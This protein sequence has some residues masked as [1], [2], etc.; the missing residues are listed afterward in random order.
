MNL[1]GRS[2][3]VCRAPHQAGPLVE[4]LTED[5]ADVVHVP[6]IDVVGAADEGA[7]LRRAIRDA[8][9]DTWWCF[10]SSNAVDAVAAAIGGQLDS[11]DQHPSPTGRLAVVGG[12]T[13]DRVRSL[14]W[15]VDA[16]AAEPTARGLG[17]SLP[18]APG[19][20]V[21]APVAE[22]AS[23]D[24]ADALRARGAVVEVITAY[25]TV[26]PTVSPTEIE[27]VVS[28]DLVLVTSP[29]VI[30]RL[31]AL[32]GDR[33]LPSLIAIGPTSAAAIEAAGHPVAERADEPT[34]AGLISAALRTLQA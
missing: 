23:N 24:L 12:A 31:T 11:G 8:G 14:G 32:V 19:D 28:S 16:V 4:A 22:L 10:T 34:V 18:V 3:V 20:R 13:A 5:G 33:S 1:T 30:R 17:R 29:S 2:V 27:R 21:I 26:T 7:A 6:L 15:T 9:P 25:R